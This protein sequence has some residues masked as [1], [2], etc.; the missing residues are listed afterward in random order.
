MFCT[1][2]KLTKKFFSPEN[3]IQ[4]IENSADPFFASASRQGYV[5]FLAF[6]KLGG[7]TVCFQKVEEDYQRFSGITQW[8]WTSNDNDEL[9]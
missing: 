9:N 3:L 2:S 6:S 8:L 7:I 5:G 4:R 1:V